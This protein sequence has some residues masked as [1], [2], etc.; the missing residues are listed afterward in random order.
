MFDVTLLWACNGGQKL[1][2]LGPAWVS[3]RFALALLVSVCRTPHSFTLCR[4]LRSSHRS[5]SGGLHC[6]GTTTLSV[7]SNVKGCLLCHCH[8][9]GPF[10][11]L[12]VFLVIVFCFGSSVLLQLS[13][14]LFSL[15]CFPAASNPLVILCIYVPVS[16]SSG[17]HH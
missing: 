13:V 12:C 17:S 5:S 11:Q 6:G 7:I 15:P 10:V 2:R 16:V 9:P 3:G 1:T 4:L 14:S 8:G